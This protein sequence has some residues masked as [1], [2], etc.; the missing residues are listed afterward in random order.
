VAS[1]GQARTLRLA[2]T[3]VEPPDAHEPET[4]FGLQDAHSHLLAG[5]PQPDGALRF[6]CEL[7]VRRHPH[8]G[9]PDFAGP[10]VHGKLGERFL[11]LSLLD[12]HTGAWVRRIKVILAGIG[13][14][15]VDVIEA[16][17]AGSLAARVVGINGARAQFEGEGWRA[18]T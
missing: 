12:V 10:Y 8:T 11:Y 5:E 2:V 1:S 18:E 15:L 13:W 17:P 7:T 6:A 9:E 3:C 16:A 14:E 4:T